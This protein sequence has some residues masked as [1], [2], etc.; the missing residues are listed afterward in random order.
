MA[1]DLPRGF[2]DERAHPSL[3][4]L[5][6]LDRDGVLNE[7]RALSVRT[8]NE[9][10][11]IPGAA[12]ALRRLNERGIKVAVVTNQSVVG[13]GIISEEML[14]RIHARLQDELRRE[15]A[16][17][18]DLLVATDPPNVPS[19]WRKPAPGMLREAMR[20][21]RA[22][23]DETVMIGDALRD[24]EA[25]AAV[26]CRR[27]LVRTGHGAATQAA[28]IPVSLLPVAIYDDFAAA[29]AALLGEAA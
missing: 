3:P 17:L 5:V 26:G 9:L 2:E 25:A 15:R 16:R 6:L 20:R 11:L 27:I 29:V 21:F 8:P 19:E 12:T 28:G 22:G 4:R 14:R 23:P 7:D 18:D 10:R 1:L 13:R 24:L